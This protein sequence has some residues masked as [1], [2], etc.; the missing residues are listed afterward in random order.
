LVA[1][2]KLQCKYQGFAVEIVVTTGKGIG[3]TKLSAFD[4]ALWDA[5]IAGYNLIYLSSVIPIG[6]KIVKK[7]YYPK[8]EEVGWRLYCVV[9]VGYLA[10][11]ETSHNWVGLGWAS[12]QDRGG[13]FIEETASTRSR[14]V[15]K[16]QGAYAQ[17]SLRR[18]EI[19]ALKRSIVQ[20]PHPHPF[21]CA[22]AAAVYKVSPW[23]SCGP[24]D[25]HVS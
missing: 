10:G 11:D 5:G 22:V 18:G 9:S 16:I 6:S 7:R 4:A 25:S 2:E 8:T 17:M 13:I 21:S 23:G 15:E 1:S 19:G 3:I 20:V 12:Q 24:I 14:L